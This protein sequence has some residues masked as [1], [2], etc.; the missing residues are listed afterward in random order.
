VARVHVEPRH[1]AEVTL[2]LR[3]TTTSDE[4]GTVLLAEAAEVAAQ[5]GAT[6]L[7]AP[8]LDRDPHAATILDGIGLPYRDEA[9]FDGP[10]AVIDLRPIVEWRELAIA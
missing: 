10:T 2:H 1:R 3:T 6:E 4:A 5:A 9:G 8:H 7:Y